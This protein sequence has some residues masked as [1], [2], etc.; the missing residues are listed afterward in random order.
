MAFKS[1]LDH[2]ITPKQ[3][4]EEGDKALEY[5]KSLALNINLIARVNRVEWYVNYVELFS[6]DK[7]TNNLNNSINFQMVKEG[8]AMIDPNSSLIDNKDWI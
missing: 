2:L 3:Y 1:K 7:Y 8:Y 5:F 6:S 4:T